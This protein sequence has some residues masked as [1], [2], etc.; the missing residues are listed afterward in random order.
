MQSPQSK[1]S[2]R[3]IAESWAKITIQLWRK[4]L[5]RLKIGQN[6][7][8]DLYRSFKFKVIAG[9]QGNVDRIDFAFL[10]YGKFLDMGVGK[11]TRLGDRPVSRGSRVLADRMLGTDRKPKKWYS[12]TFYGESQRLI[13]ILQKEYGRR[14]QLVI[15]ENIGDNSIR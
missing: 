15:S 8:G 5:S 11:G 7:S 4:N 12:R 14:A 10:Y 13:E 6:S 3:E 2:E 1:L 9:A